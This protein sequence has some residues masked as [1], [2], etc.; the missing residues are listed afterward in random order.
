MAEVI[1]TIGDVNVPEY[2]G[3]FVI[4][5]EGP[6][7]RDIWGDYEVE[8]VQTPPDDLDFDDR[9]ARWTVYRVSL[10]PEVPT[11]GDIRAVSRTSG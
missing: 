3:G 4:E 9:R 10:D 6:D 11:W 1:D 5:R 8:Y 7:Q 2:D